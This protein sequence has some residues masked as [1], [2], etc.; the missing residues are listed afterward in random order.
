MLSIFTLLNL[1]LL[2]LNE[3][4]Q[5]EK[6]EFKQYKLGCRARD[7]TGRTNPMEEKEVQQHG[8]LD[9]LLKRHCYN[10][11]PDS[12]K[13]E[14]RN[15]WKRKGWAMGGG[16]HNIRP[17]FKESIMRSGSQER[18]S[19]GKEWIS[20]QQRKPAEQWKIRKYIYVTKLTK[21]SIISAP[22]SPLPSL[23][24]ACPVPRFLCPFQTAAAYFHFF[25]S[26][27]QSFF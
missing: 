23:L 4:K 14:I 1:L 22:F 11:P 17:P 10:A 24:A 18:R 16:Q 6:Y 20:A 2:L 5:R 9:V 13:Y 25:S 26:I 12:T 3:T 15:R 27:I 21:L 7:S 8:E 19:E